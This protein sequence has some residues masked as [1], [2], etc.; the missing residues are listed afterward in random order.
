MEF[1]TIKQECKTEPVETMSFKSENTMDFKKELDDDDTFDHRFLPDNLSSSP[2][3]NFSHEQNQARQLETAMTQMDDFRRVIQEL[4]KE[5]KRLVDEAKHYFL[6]SK[7]VKESQD[8]ENA[9]KSNKTMAMKQWRI[10]IE[11]NSNLRQENEKLKLVL[12]KKGLE[13]KK[14]NL[15]AKRNV[16][17]I[18]TLKTKVSNLEDLVRQLQSDL[19]KAQK[20]ASEN[21]KQ[22][23]NAKFIRELDEINELVSKHG[24]RKLVETR[25]SG[26]VSLSKIPRV[27]S[28]PIAKRQ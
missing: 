8:S 18:G 7:A 28:S 13:I 10:A 20:K 15:A 22:S 5:N 26:S 6:Y 9:T 25:A 16:S 27:A 23:V 24:Q 1:K 2:T 11:N 19:D 12:E 17:E 4:T 21:E 14:I 3:R